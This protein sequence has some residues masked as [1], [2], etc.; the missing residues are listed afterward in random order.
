MTGQRPRVEVKR[1]NMLNLEVCKKL[2]QQN[3]QKYTDD[4]VKR[5]RQ[6]IYKLGELDYELF[7]AQKKTP[8]ANSHHL[9]QGIDG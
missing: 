5:I 9:H 2:L 6:L 4:D 1:L 8:H 3:G 7:T